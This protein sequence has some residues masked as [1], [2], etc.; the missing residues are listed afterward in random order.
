MPFL[1]IIRDFGDD[2][3]IEVAGEA[4]R[5]GRAHSNDVRLEDAAA[6]REHFELRREGESYSIRDLGSR[7][8]TVVN[9]VP[10]TQ[11]IKVLSADR[12]QDEQERHDEDRQGCKGDEQVEITFTGHATISLPSPPRPP[13][14]RSRDSCRPAGHCSP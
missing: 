13:A 2:H 7:N 14:R 5:A 6:S 12:T 3:V 8:G 1:R 10:L 4:M 9:G 11:E